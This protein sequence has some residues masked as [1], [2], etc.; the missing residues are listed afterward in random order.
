MC[1]MPTCALPTARY[2]T[3]DAPGAACTAGQPPALS[4]W[5]P[6]PGTYAVSM[7]ESGAIAGYVIDANNV[8]HGYLRAPDGTMTMFD[9][10]G[11]GTDSG[12]GTKAGNM[13]AGAIRATT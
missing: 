7:D 3:F 13:S 10:P 5:G 8:M 4:G 6:A 11:A 12:Q 2:T 9:V 1:F